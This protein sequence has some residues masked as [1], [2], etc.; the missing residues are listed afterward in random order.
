MHENKGQSG[1]LYAYCF[2]KSASG[3]TKKWMLQDRVEA[4]EVD[5]TCEFFPGSFTITD[6]DS[7]AVGEVAFLYKLS[8]KGD[9]SPD[10]KN[11]FCMRGILNMPFGGSTIIEYDQHREGGEKKPDAQFVKAARPIQ[12]FAMAQWEKY[13]YTKY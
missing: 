6:S 7:N 9:V 11:S 4:C 8:C 1:Y 3:W 5:A 12:A 13:G 2:D 10:E